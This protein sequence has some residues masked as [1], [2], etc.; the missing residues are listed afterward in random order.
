MMNKTTPTMIQESND[1]S[2]HHV[3]SQDEVLSK[4]KDDIITNDTKSTIKRVSFLENPVVFVKE[5]PRI[6]SGLIP[7]LFYSQQELI[8]M[9]QEAY[10]QKVYEEA[11]KIKAVR[12]ARDSR[13][14]PQQQ[15]RKLTQCQIQPRQTKKKGKV[16]LAA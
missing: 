15:H 13:F 2:N 1:E 9:K 5:T 4:A 11:R 10:V 16:A 14:S 6:E 8:M 12:E 3:I 7:E